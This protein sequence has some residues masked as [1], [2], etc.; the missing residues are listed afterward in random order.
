[1]GKQHAGTRSTYTW[2]RL[3]G[4]PK[5]PGGE[6]FNYSRIAGVVIYVNG[7]EKRIFKNWLDIEMKFFFFSFEEKE[8]IVQ[9]SLCFR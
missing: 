1:M 2:N 6:K 3:Q 9:I 4:D 5:N 8:H 7:V